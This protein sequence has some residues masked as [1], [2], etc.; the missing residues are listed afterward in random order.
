MRRL[1]ALLA[2][3]GM[4]VLAGCMG[5]VIS[6]EALS[7]EATYDWNTSSTVTVDVSG[8]SYT[9]V[10]TLDNVSSIELY[11]RGDLGGEEPIPIRAIKFRYP[12]GTVVNASA[13]DVS[14]T[15]SRTVV[16][17]PAADGQFAYT[18]NSGNGD[19]FFPVVVN[20][21][22]EVLLPPGTRISAPIIGVA[23]PAGFEKT[24]VEDR[25]RLVWPAPDRDV[26]TVSY[27]LQRDLYIFGGLIGLLGVVAGGG[28]LYFRYQIRQLAKNREGVD[29]ESEEEQ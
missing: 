2:V 19:L 5:G 13:M 11:H 23:E 28:W 21:S 22:H 12:N 7:E 16:E 10:Y 18:A 24:M 20:G 29:V 1:V 4:V 25:V 6:E 26:I 15:D 14:E 3:L 8:S 9:A 17:F 27:Y